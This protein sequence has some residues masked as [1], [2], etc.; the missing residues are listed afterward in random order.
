MA[1]LVR[2]RPDLVVVEMGLPARRPA[3]AGCVRTYGAARV[4][5]LAAVELMLDA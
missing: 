4:S 1:E 2:R 3:A 5:V